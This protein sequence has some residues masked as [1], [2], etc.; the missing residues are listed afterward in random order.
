MTGDTTAPSAGS[1]LLLSGP[2]GAGKT[3]IARARRYGRPIDR[4]SQDRS[5]LAVR[6]TVLGE[7]GRQSAAE[8]RAISSTRSEDLQVS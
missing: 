4:A 5:L 1:L 7:V 2:P 3:T 8:R 6:H